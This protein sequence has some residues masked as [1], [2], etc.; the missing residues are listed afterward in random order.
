MAHKIALINMKGGVGKS[1]LAAN[2]AWE[3]ATSPWNKNVLVGRH[4]PAI[5]LQPI[6]HRGSA[7]GRHYHHGRSDRVG[8]L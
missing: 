6:P 5:Q 3:M 7:Y 2:L 4:R 8:Y 1:T